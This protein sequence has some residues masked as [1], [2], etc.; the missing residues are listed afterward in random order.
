[1]PVTR[2]T[3]HVVL[4]P[5]PVPLPV[6][7]TNCY[8]LDTEDGFIL[9]D[10]GMDTPDARTAWQAYDAELGLH[11]NR[12]RLI[13]VTHFHPD[14]LGLAHW[15]SD[16]FEAP[17]AMM[18]GD[19]DTAEHYL[20]SPESLTDETARN[21]YTAHG[22]PHDLLES[23]RK[24]DDA[25]HQ[26]LSL[27]AVIERYHDGQTLNIGALRLQLIEQG[28]H[29]DHQ[30]LVYLED[31]NLLFTGD[32][33]LARI[34][35]NVSRWPAGHSNPLD[36]YLNSLRMLLKLGHPQGLPAHEAMLDDVNV[37]IHELIAHH[38][39]RNRDILG[40]LGESPSSAYDLTPKLF[41]RNLDGYQFRFALG[42]ALAHL[43]FLTQQDTVRVSQ[44]HGIWIYECS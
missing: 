31:Q 44:S 39:R 41:R 36:A 43:E 26:T 23:W 6:H 16:R 15:L 13:F 22:V 30:G 32:Q 37:R 17:V 18:A 12:V 21:F 35:P 5:V 29:T 1:M 20:D 9:I 27:P 40:I 2:I 4:L 25:F 28:G 14:H 24:L 33:V 34:T 38:D 11:R 19:A 8:A 7:H 3:P 10:T 42:E